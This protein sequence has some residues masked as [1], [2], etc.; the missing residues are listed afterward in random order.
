LGFGIY[1][2]ERKE[3]GIADLGFGILRRGKERI[4]DCGFGI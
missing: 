1:E 4:W 2:E 3:F